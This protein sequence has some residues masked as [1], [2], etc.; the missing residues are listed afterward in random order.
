MNN[1]FPGRPE[2][3]EKLLYKLKNNIFDSGNFLEII[4]NQ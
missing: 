4:E 2:L 1:K 3:L